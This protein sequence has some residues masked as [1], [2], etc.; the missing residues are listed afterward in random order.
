MKRTVSFLLI[1][2]VALVFAG[3]SG[4]GDDYDQNQI[5]QKQPGDGPPPL[6]RPGDGNPAPPATP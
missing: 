4:G 3:C 1:G 6:A 2:V 5:I